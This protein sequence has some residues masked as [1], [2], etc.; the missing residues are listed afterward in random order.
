MLLAVFHQGAAAPAG[1]GAAAQGDLLDTIRDATRTQQAME[2]DAKKLQQMLGTQATL[3]GRAR[4]DARS[5]GGAG[6]QLERE[7]PSPAKAPAPAKAPMPGALPAWGAAPWAP[8]WGAG[9]ARAGA[10]QKWMQGERKI[11]DDLEAEEEVAGQAAE[12]E[13]QME[14]GT[15]LE[16]QLYQ[17]LQQAAHTQAQIDAA[18]RVL[19]GFRRQEHRATA[20]PAAA[21]WP[22]ARAPLP[23]L[24]PSLRELKAE[25]GALLDDAVQH[26]SAQQELERQIDAIAQAAAPPPGAQAGVLPWRGGPMMGAW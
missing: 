20:G 3:L 8:A 25:Q 2:T 24:V 16:G 9:A 5:L 12:L 11:S 7:A 6:M 18:K 23:Y 22:V 19:A 1:P 26:L 21:A 10:W 14:R 15:A 4:D 17:A 13:Q